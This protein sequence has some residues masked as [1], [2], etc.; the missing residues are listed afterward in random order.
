MQTT[1]DPYGVN[2][3]PGPVQNSMFPAWQGDTVHLPFDVMLPDG[4]MAT[5]DNCLLEFMLKDR[6]FYHHPLWKGELNNGIV[7]TRPGAVMVHIPERVT[8]H[9]RR[10]SYLYSL[11]VWTRI[12]DQRRLLKEGSIS[13]EYSAGAPNPSVYYNCNHENQNFT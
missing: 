12:R 4:G 9:L 13:V 8:A 1:Y 6:R 7:F 11:T 3:R 2:P 10:G 5:A